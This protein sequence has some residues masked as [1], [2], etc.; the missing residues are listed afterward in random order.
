M[1]K[2]YYFYLMATMDMKFSKS[3]YSPKVGRSLKVPNF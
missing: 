1:V 2:K 3:N